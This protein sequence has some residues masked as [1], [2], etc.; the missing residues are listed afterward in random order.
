MQGRI[1]RGDGGMHPPPACSE[2]FPGAVMLCGLKLKRAPEQQASC[3]RAISPSR[4]DFPPPGPL[5]LI[6]S[7]CLNWMEDCRRVRVTPTAW[8]NPQWLAATSPVTTFDIL[9]SAAAA[10]KR[11]QRAAMCHPDHPQT[12]CSTLIASIPLTALPQ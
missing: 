12:S 4:Y 5:P 9:P 8:P 11:R 10:C 2:F 1:Q 6:C 7:S 3:S